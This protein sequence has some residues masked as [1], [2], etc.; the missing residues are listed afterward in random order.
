MNITKK[1]LLVACLITAFPFVVFAHPGRTDS[2]GCHTCRTNCPNWGLSYDEYH[3]HNAKALPQPKEPIRS[4]FGENGTGWTESWPEYQSPASPAPSSAV[5][6]VIPKISVPNMIF[7]TLKRGTSGSEVTAL[8]TKLAKN[9]AV[10][11]EGLITGYYGVA[12]ERAV[13]RFQRK[14]GLE[15]VGFVGPKTRALLNAQ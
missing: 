3:C 9:P 13:I 4:H 11:P 1:I 12:T 6:V 15:Q 14:N 10:Y 7:S 8:Q 5:N 2:S